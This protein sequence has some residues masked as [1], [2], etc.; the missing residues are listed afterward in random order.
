VVTDKKVREGEVAVVIM[1]SAA[2]VGLLVVVVVA[3]D[4]VMGTVG[5]VLLDVELELEWLVAEIFDLEGDGCT[6]LGGKIS[7]RRLKPCCHCC[8]V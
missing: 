2:P 3:V 4:A 7:E 5:S 1:P 8:Q 6:V